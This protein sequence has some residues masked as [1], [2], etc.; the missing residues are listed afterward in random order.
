MTR[1][2][3]EFVVLEEL[4]TRPRLLRTIRLIAALR[5]IQLVRKI[6]EPAHSYRDTNHPRRVWGLLPHF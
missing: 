6:I 5:T 1:D 2:Q 3:E 4:A